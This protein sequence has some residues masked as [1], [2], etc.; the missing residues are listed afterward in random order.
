MAC[1][2]GKNMWTRQ[3]KNMQD[4]SQ[5][6]TGTKVH[7]VDVAK[8]ILQKCN[9]S[10][11]AERATKW[12]PQLAQMATVGVPTASYSESAAKEK[13]KLTQGNTEDV[14]LNQLL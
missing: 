5:N 1:M 10:R 12:A 14:F 13:M 6:K 11:E 8:A 4:L 9:I 2:A 3:S 7:A